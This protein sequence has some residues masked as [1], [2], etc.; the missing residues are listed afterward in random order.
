M[1]IA[2][3][4]HRGHLRVAE[5]GRPFAE[6]A[7]SIQCIMLRFLA[8]ACGCFKQTM[9]HHQFEVQH[10]YKRPSRGRCAS[11]MPLQAPEARAVE[12]FI[13]C[14]SECASVLF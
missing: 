13:L 5:D 11:R 10:R 9:F 14:P 8:V 12:G 4:E 1:G 7:N 2:V 6:T 3:E